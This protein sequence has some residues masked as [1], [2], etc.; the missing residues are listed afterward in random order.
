ML[1]SLPNVES[2]DR[3]LL[4]LLRKQGACSITELATAM[5]VTAT[6]VRQRLSRLMG[7]GLVTRETT[8][9]ARGRPS[10]RYALTDKALRQSGHNFVDLSLAL[11]EEIRSIKDPEIRGG[12]LKRLSERMANQY[13][14]QIRGETLEERF[15]SVVALFGSRNVPLSVDY[16][17]TNLP[18]AAPAL[19]ETTASA[20]IDVA[21][22]VSSPELPVLSVWA[23]PYP[24]LAEQDRGI[25]SLEKM[26]LT[27]LLGTRVKLTE[28]RLDGGN[29]CRFQT[30]SVPD[31]L[32][33]SVV[34]AS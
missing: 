21:V 4:D 17:G 27:D 22:P 12:L 34:T 31:I 13:R 11:W 24:Q 20:A 23:C 30:S 33:N 3:G 15:E 10:H 9:P 8:K 5:Q 16:V 7:L 6:A 29:C 26:L 1:A 28:C 18:P 19:A 14:S 2:S 25:C 32:E